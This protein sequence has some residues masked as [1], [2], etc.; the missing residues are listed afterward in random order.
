[1]PLPAVAAVLARL[2][3]VG[4]TRA[5]AGTAAGAEARVLTSVGSS[6]AKAY[7]QSLMGAAESAANRRRRRGKRQGDG[8]GGE[9]SK[10]GEG[11]GGESSGSQPLVKPV[12]TV[13]K[14]L[15]L[16]AAA[17]VTAT[18]ATHKLSSALLESQRGLAKWHGGIAATMAQLNLQ[19][20]Q[21]EMRTARHTAGSVQSLGRATMSLNETLQPLKEDFAIIQ[22]MV[23][24]GVTRI[25]DIGLKLAGKIPGVG[26]L[27]ELIQEWDRKN[28]KEQGQPLAEVIAKLAWAEY[29]GRM[30]RPP[31]NAEP[32]M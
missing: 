25:V 6:N 1:M 10:G 26:D 22:N 17:A 30:P 3:A 15:S 7:T 19:R 18:V 27:H 9:Q 5:A 4:G 11:T 21:L 31:Y 13:V 23:M 14:G 20:M 12:M 29:G 8:E 24:T 28:R 32:Q 16:L 2:A